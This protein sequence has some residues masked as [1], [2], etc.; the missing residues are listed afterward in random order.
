MCKNLHKT[1][2]NK[3][4]QFFC[5]CLLLYVVY[6]SQPFVCI[7]EPFLTE[8]YKYNF[9]ENNIHKIFFVHSHVQCMGFFLYCVKNGKLFIETTVP[10]VSLLL[11]LFCSNNSHSLSMNWIEMEKIVIGKTFFFLC[12]CY[13]IIFCG[14][15]VCFSS[16]KSACYSVLCL[17][18]HTWWQ[19]CRIYTR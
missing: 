2:V 15:M 3:K 16:K 13:S 14:A 17:C 11:S 10:A 8:K 4:P 9:G 7:P 19:S 12:G 6:G 1:T 18:G 5:T